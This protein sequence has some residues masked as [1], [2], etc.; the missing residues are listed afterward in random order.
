MTRAVSK[1]II[2][3][4]TLAVASCGQDGGEE[5][6]K[7]Q[8]VANIDGKDITIHELNAELAGV[9]VANAAQQDVVKRTMLQRLIDRR[10]LADY[11]RSEKL[12]ESP[13]YAIQK[14][15]AEEMIL[16]NLLQRQAVLKLAPTTRED[17][18]RFMAHHPQIFAE[19]KIYD[20]DQIVFEIPRNTALLKAMQP[21]KSLEAIEVLLV[22]NKIRY[23]RGAARLDAVKADPRLLAAIAKLPTDEIFVIPLGRQAAASQVVGV[24]VVPFGGDDAI[25]FAQQAAQRKRLQ[26]MLTREL[27][28]VIARGRAAL[29]Y[30][31]GFAPGPRRGAGGGSA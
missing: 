16:V 2:L 5:L 8:V 15:R 11:A 29:R 24:H 10:I 6:P 13:E 31:P 30:Q 23:R 14:H 22:R 12:D 1:A 7:G 4:T 28:P 19:R 9:P 20:L 18:Q 26:D 17:A 27:D 25:A 3:A 21:L